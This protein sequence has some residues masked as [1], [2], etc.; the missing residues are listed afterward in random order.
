ML[1]VAAKH[2]FHFDTVQMPVNIMDARFRSF[3]TEILPRLVKSGIA[4]LAMKTFGGSYIVNHIKAA[5]TATPI[6]LLHY[7]MSQPVSV[8]ITGIDSLAVLDQAIEAARTFKPMTAAQARSLLQRTQVAQ[9][10]GK[11]E[12]YKTTQNFDST[13]KHPEYLG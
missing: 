8:V 13:A 4:P 6:E 10:N 5:G 2:N 12:L 7:S 11:Y 1:D 9:A 3:T